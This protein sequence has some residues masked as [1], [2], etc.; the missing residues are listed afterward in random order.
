M[1]KLVCKTPID[2]KSKD[3][4][5]SGTRW[6]IVGNAFKLQNGSLRIVLDALPCNGVIVVMRDDRPPKGES[7]ATATAT[8]N[9]SDDDIPFG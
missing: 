5:R 7:P 9:N 8:A 1:S 4:T 3:G 6:P 2:W